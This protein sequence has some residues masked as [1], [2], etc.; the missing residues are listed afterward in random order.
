MRLKHIRKAIKHKYSTK[1]WLKM[2]HQ[3]VKG[4]PFEITRHVEM[5]SNCG[6]DYDRSYMIKGNFDDKYT[7]F[8]CMD[9]LGPED[10]PVGLGTKGYSQ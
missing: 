5:C 3:K 9:G 10:L 8:D 1:N 2:F 7:C 6:F 4:V